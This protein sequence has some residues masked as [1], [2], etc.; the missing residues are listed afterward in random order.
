MR[1]PRAARALDPIEAWFA[2]RGWKP[3]PFQR[4]A[5]R[6]DLEGCSGLIQVATGAGKTYAALLGPIAR[7]LA[8]PE[9][10]QPGLRLLVL[11]PLRALSRDLVAAIREP[12]EAMGWPLRVGL[13]N[14]DTSPSERGRQLRN[15]PHILITTPESLSLLL[16]NRG[17]PQL[18]AHLETVVLDEWHELIGGKRGVQ[19]ELCLSWLRGLRPALRT[20]AVSATIGNPAEA[21]RAAV[22]MDNPKPSVIAAPVRRA[23][24]LR[25]LLPDSVDGFPWAG[26]LGLRMHES[27][28]AALDP[29]VSTLLF[30]NTRNQAERWYQC[31]RYACPEM[32]GALALHHS[33]ID[34]AE[35]ETIEAGVKEG[36][37]RWVVCTA[38]LDLGVDFQP[39]ERVVQIGSAKN[40]A[41]LL[42]RAGRSA[43]RPGGTAQVLFLPT[44]ALELLELS[45]LRRGL[46]EGLVERRSPPQAPLDVLLQHLMSL[47]CGPGFDPLEQWRQVRSC[48]SY[49]DL[50]DADWAWCLRFLEHGGD[51]L[52]AYPRYRKL[53]RD[54]PEAVD[55]SP[56]RFLV[57]EAAIARLHRLAIGTITA[58]RAVTVRFLRGAVLG[59]VEESFISRLK[60]GDAF[61][62]AGRQLEFVRLREMTA[63]VKATTKRSTTVPAW[64]GGQMALS[65]LLSRRLREELD[66]CA[67]AL[68]GEGELDT[69]ELQAL[70]PLLARQADLSR[71]PR[72]SQFLVEICRSREGSHLYAYPFEGR[73]VHEGLGFLWA[74]R[75]A[76]QRPAT[77]TVSVNDYGFELLAAKGYPFEELLDLY[78]RDLLDGADLEADLEASIN[79]SELCRRRFRAIAQVSGLVHNGYPGQGKS[80]GQLQISAALLFDVFTRHEPANR[81]LAQARREVLAEQL[82]KHRLEAALERLRASELVVE[83][84]ARPGPLAFPLLAERLNNRM[85]NESLLER[86]GRL[87]REAER[88]EASD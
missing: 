25:S 49:R 8:E 22:G 47:A 21:A 63:Y 85:S 56:F 31:L 87:Q 76:R 15:P 81:L 61:F 67:L 45:A 10:P 37:I 19:S 6:A 34:R 84:T 46:A 30:T 64:A 55:G 7:L 27:L 9:G 80:G 54:P 51:C 3:L 72:R 29:A 14:G 43:H 35:R 79:L 75:L 4:L 33:A 83:H 18:F 32:E 1:Q 44:N 59:H 39:V 41:R 53:E 42:Q 48:W 2:Q 88:A 57:R 20:W 74:W 60:P 73:F 36:T 78:R 26:H 62:F 65:D 77:F 28:V 23:T 5:W 50:S 13:R 66:R 69:A 16:A 17:A 82:E 38:S 40:V 70:E 52:A 71:L 86:L 24:E 11:T 58:D 12:I 68:A